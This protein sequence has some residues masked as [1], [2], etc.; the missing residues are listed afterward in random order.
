MEVECQND[1]NTKPISDCLHLKYYCFVGF[2]MVI[3]YHWELY[4]SA[5]F[6]LCLVNLLVCLHHRLQFS[7]YFQFVRLLF[8]FL[9]AVPNSFKLCDPFEEVSAP[10]LRYWMRCTLSFS[11]SGC[12]IVSSSSSF[13]FF[14]LSRAYSCRVIILRKS[15]T[16]SL[17]C[18]FS[19]RSCW[20][21]SSAR[22]SCLWDFVVSSSR[23]LA[24]RS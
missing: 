6:G 2:N 4:L 10:Q 17:S 13:S 21:S 9:W 3:E 22:A 19:R 16:D 20:H 12:K 8:I 23:E 1:E 14:C 7:Y 5:I 15:Y 24:L 11:G 18:L